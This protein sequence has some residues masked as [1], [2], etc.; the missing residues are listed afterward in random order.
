MF[1]LFVLL[2]IPAISIGTVF[3]QVWLD[4][5]WL[6]A[7]FVTINVVTFLAYGLDKLMTCIDGML[8]F[9]WLGLP[10]PSA[11]LLWVLPLLGGGIGAFI[12][13][14]LFS[15]YSSD[16]YAWYWSAIAGILFV[17]I[18][19]V[20]VLYFVRPDLLAGFNTTIEQ[21]SVYL[22]GLS[23]QLFNQLEQMLSSIV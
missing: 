5:T 8:L 23:I 14:R 7:Y 1:I 16:V 9:R 10:V 3:I 4:I 6:L 11:I 18:V 22:A 21:I 19:F 17:Q 12:G 15:H 13:G 2:L 20:V